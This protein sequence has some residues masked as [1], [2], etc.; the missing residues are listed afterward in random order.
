[1]P[2]QLR[3]YLVLDILSRLPSHGHLQAA[4]AMQVHEG[5]VQ[6]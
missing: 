6:G 3:D 2:E 1:M 5:G 4:H